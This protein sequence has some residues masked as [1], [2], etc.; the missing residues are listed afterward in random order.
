MPKQRRWIQR[1]L[2]FDTYVAHYALGPS[3]EEEYEKKKAADLKR[4]HEMY[5]P[6]TLHAK[7][8]PEEPTYV[9]TYINGK[10]C[11][12]GRLPEMYPGQHKGKA[13]DYAG[14]LLR[15]N[16]KDITDIYDSVD[17]EQQQ[18]IY[19]NLKTYIDLHDEHAAWKISPDV[20]ALWN[21]ISENK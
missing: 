13:P 4:I 8:K 3:C 12:W 11:P 20:E 5:T 6:K 19:E 7:K 21:R 16:G 15:W 1:K 2:N 17:T 9:L 10:Y 18:K 14:N